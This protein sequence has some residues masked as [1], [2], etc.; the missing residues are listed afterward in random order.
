MRGG[1]SRS[2]AILLPLAAGCRV[3]ASI[4]TSLEAP[5]G[6]LAACGPSL[7]LAAATAPDVDATT[8]APADFEVCPGIGVAGAFARAVFPADDGLGPGVGAGTC[9]SMCLALAM[10]GELGAWAVADAET[11]DWGAMGEFSV[12]FGPPWGVP[13]VG[14]AGLALPLWDEG[15]L[16]LNSTWLCYVGIL[17]MVNTEGS[18]GFSLSARYAWYSEDAT[19]GGAPT[20]L[21]GWSVAFAWY[22]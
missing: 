2:I 12:G 1:L 19:I 15:E 10:H 18:K 14:G 21:D 22:F 11:D 13:L 7:P 17:L 4:P 3:P 8:P 9:S 6:T 5:N 20:D 16:D